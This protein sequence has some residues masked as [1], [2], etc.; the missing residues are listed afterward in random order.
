MATAVAVL[1][2][3]A[4][5]APADDIS[6]S[7]CKVTRVDD[8]IMVSASFAL[9][10]LHL[11]GNEQLYITPVMADDLGHSVSLPAVLVSGRNMHYAIERGTVKA[12]DANHPVVAM[13]TRRLN[14][15]PQTLSYLANIP[16]EKWMMGSTAEISF[17]IDECG[18]GAPKGKGEMPGIP[19]ALNP[20]LEMEVPFVTSVVSEIPVS[21]HNGKARI[22]FEVDRT[23]LHPE[24][25][26]CKNGQ[27]I[28]NRAEL[29]VIGDS[30]EY[31]LSDPNVEIAEMSICGYAS[32]ESPY[33]HNEQLAMGRS[34]ALSEYIAERYNLPKGVSHY[35]SVP[36]NWEEFRE[37]VVEAK[38]IT[39]QQRT[40]LLELIDHPTYGAPDFDR[41]E[42][43]LKTDPRF[44]TLYRTK[45][46][47][48]WF[49]KLRATK[50]AIKTRLKPLSDDKLAEVILNTPDKMS[51][52]QMY[53]VAHLYPEGSEEY[54]RS[55]RIAQ[56]YYGDDPVANLNSAVTAIRAA[57]VEGINEA[58]QTRLIEEADKFLAKAGDGPEAENARGL[59]A[60]LKGDFDAARRHFEAA[61][62]L[63]DA[64]KNLD[65]LK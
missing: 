16:F 52:N 54:N 6:T 18:C 14:G 61:L 41:K 60:T 37:M 47:P 13:E 58:E 31:A 15:K 42:K 49:P 46:L 11:G 51:L 34:R 20:A 57:N 28:D 48:Q 22:Q 36:E 39:E 21:I 27:L 55:M 59:L 65:L 7:E 44:A 62:P 5:A 64:Q 3:P 9:D 25:Y 38:D 33:L 63:P 53:R 2:M 17:P 8:K 1:A 43:I 40:D 4:A 32:P 56:L 26:R 45:I 35:S 50:F 23:E 19:L 30:L 12:T 24:P 29:K 10:N